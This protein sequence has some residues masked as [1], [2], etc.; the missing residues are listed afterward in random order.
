LFTISQGPGD[1]RIGI[2]RIHEEQTAYDSFYVP[3]SLYT[4]NYLQP[5]SIG[6]GY[7]M[8][9]IPDTEELFKT[10]AGYI[11]KGILI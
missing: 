5:G 7:K 1:I 4:A 2:Q 3:P 11:I 8:K 9:S 10:T 6:K